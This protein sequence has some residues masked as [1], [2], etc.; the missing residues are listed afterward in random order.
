MVILLI[1]KSPVFSSINSFGKIA[2]RLFIGW[3]SWTSVCCIPRSSLQ[4]SN[5]TS[6]VCLF[7]PHAA[8]PGSG[9]P[10]NTVLFYQ[11]VH[12]T[13]IKTLWYTESDSGMCYLDTWEI[14]DISSS[15]QELQM[16]GCVKNVAPLS[17]IL[18]KEL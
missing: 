10:G 12:S 9:F 4:T 16:G 13:Y 2:C 7:L 1:L 17:L 15:F 14:F 5:G 6:V 11:V 18:S 8:V 3:R